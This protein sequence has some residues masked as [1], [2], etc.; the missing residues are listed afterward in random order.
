M[1]RIVSYCILEEAGDQ[2]G[3][4]SI[5]SSEIAVAYLAANSIGEGGS[6][7]ATFIMSSGNP[8]ILK[9]YAPNNDDPVSL[10]LSAWNTI[11][12]AIA[13]FQNTDAR[14][15]SL[16]ISPLITKINPSYQAQFFNNA[17]SLSNIEEERLVLK[18]A[19][20]KERLAEVE[21]AASKA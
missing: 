18:D 7:G 10:P 5:E 4:S 1:K 13:T 17:E 15:V 8:V 16:D 2:K 20:L 6:N 3:W 14:I 19:A 12:E 21:A 11:F 9:V